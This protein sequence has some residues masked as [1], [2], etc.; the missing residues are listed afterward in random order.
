MVVPLKHKN[1]KI[2]KFVSQN[3]HMTLIS[4]AADYKVRVIAK[5]YKSDPNE[6]KED[7]EYL[8]RLENKATSAIKRFNQKK[9]IVNTEV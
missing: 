2:K 7:Q 5:S 1:R 9:D 4:Q 8:A 3:I 6:E